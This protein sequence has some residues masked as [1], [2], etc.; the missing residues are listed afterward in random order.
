VFDGTR[1]D[2]YTESDS[3]APLNIYGRTKVEGERRVLALLPDAL[4]VRTSA[5]FGPWDQHNFV[6]RALSALAT[7]QTFR[8]S[9]DEIVSPTYVP[10][11]VDTSLDL[12]IDDARGLWHLA[13][14]GEVTWAEFARRAAA[15]AGLDTG[16]IVPCSGADLGRAARRPGYSVLGTERGALLP[17]LDDSLA[18]Y[19]RDCE[20]LGSAA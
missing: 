7:G 20:A 16:R 13:N 9:A 3:V 10:D 18:R 2:P 4:V 5:F 8:A 6:T 11:L 12:L 15:V 1:Q 17:N 19:V 14:A